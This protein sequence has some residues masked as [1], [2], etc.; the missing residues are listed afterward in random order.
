M[1][2]A[3]N[4]LREAAPNGNAFIIYRCKWDSQNHPCNLW[5]EG[6]RKAVGK[7]LNTKHGVSTTDKNNMRCLWDS[8]TDTV[9][10]ENMARHVMSRVHLDAK[11]Q[12]LGCDGQYA[13]GDSYQRHAESSQS[14]YIAGS[15]PLPGQSG[16][17]VPSNA[18]FLL[19]PPSQ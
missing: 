7:H 15:R 11:V 13:R 19:D 17:T 18:E 3:V 5:I 1:M 8:C 12:C 2:M 4:A 14:C 9:R 16:Q 10:G 6:S